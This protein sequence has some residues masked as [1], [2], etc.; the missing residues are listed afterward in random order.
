V[1]NLKTVPMKRIF[2]A[3]L[4]LIMLSTS[5]FGQSFG[6]GLRG[7]FNFSSIPSAQ[8]AEVGQ[9]RFHGLSESYTGWHLGV[10]TQLIFAGF[11]LQPELLY[12]RTGQEMRRETIGGTAQEDLYFT[13]RYDHLVMPVTAGAKFGPLRIGA[14]P[15]LS[16][17]ID[18]RTIWDTAQ[19][20]LDQDTRSVTLGFRAGVG[21][22]LGNL[23]LDL[24]YET[25]LTQFGERFLV[26]G[27]AVTFSTR[28]RQFILSLGLLL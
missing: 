27:D 26:N 2:I 21:I 17:L 22:N 8:T 20:Q 6:I 10:V 5:I 15:V 7:G 24:K 9:H 4:L 23:L 19:T 13:Q 1:L 18:E 25:S 3:S 16:A 12:T 11:Y 28:P 14:G